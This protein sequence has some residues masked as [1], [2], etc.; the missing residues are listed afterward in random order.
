MQRAALA[1]FGFALA[2]IGATSIAAGESEWLFVPDPE[3]PQAAM[4]SGSTWVGVGPG[5]TLRVQAIDEAQ[6]QAFIRQVAGLETDPFA[7]PPG[8]APRFLTFLAQLENNGSGT[9]VFRAPQCWL[10]TNR[11]EHLSPIGME[12]LQATYGV[13]GQSMSPAY[14]HVGSAF[15]PTARDLGP[16]DS[17]AGLLVYNMFKP[18]TKR[19]RLE[20]QI[21]TPSGDVVPITAAYRRVRQE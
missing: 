1:R 18:Q 20:I 4:L 14:E 15:L 16:G 17:L 12:S 11:N 13:M 19:Y 2:M 10:I 8:Q 5:F 9:L 7:T 21:T 3:A 6:R